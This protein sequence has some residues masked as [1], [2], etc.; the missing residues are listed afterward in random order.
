M[1]TEIDY[2]VEV[3]QDET[4]IRGNAIA[5]GDDEGDREVED[6]LID[7][8]NRGDVWAWACVRVIATIEGTDL[9]GE[10][11]WLGGCSYDSTRDF[12]D[13]KFTITDT[14]TGEVTHRGYYDDMCDEARDDLISKIK[15]V[16]RLGEVG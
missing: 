12:I 10:S 1:T 4:E 8:V 9:R 13:S 7:R 15:A 16:Q 2:E 11:S 6:A 3:E 14:A 5:S